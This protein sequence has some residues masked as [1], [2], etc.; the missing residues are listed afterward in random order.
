MIDPTTGTD[1]AGSEFAVTGRASRSYAVDDNNVKHKLQ[2]A[3][4][5]TNGATTFQQLTGLPAGPLRVFIWP[6]DPAIRSN[7][8]GWTSGAFFQLNVT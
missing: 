8:G 1:W 4:V 7:D 3:T 6:L 5:G 2:I